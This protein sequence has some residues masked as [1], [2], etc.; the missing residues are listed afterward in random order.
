MVNTGLVMAF[1]SIASYITS[2]YAEWFPIVFLAAIAFTMIIAFIYVL[3]KLA[4][5]NGIA[6]W[7]RIKIYEIFLSVV[8]IFA[9]L[10]VTSIIFSIDFSQL[11]G[12]AGI[13]PA[14][15]PADCPPSLFPPSDLITLSVCNIHRFNQNVLNLNQF[16]YGIGLRFSF[17]PSLTFN[18][19]SLI[20][21]TTEIE[22]LGGAATISPP[23]AFSVFTGWVIDALYGAY[24]LAQMQYI[25]LSASLLLFTILMALGLVSRMFVATRSFGAAMI[26]LGLG[27]GLMYPLMVSI[28]YGWLNVQLD[29]YWLVFG[30]GSALTIVFGIVGLIAAAIFNIL[31]NGFWTPFIGFLEF[32]G[33][34]ALGLT[35]IPILNLV[36]VD[37]FVSDFSRAFGEK[38]DFLSLLFKIV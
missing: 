29:K 22:G 9:F 21:K 28:T 11:L 7:A 10:F 15:S 31:L 33:F 5:R 35:V 18:A 23:S 36:V 3:S 1:T 24:V 12:G 38:I 14:F 32:A 26:A 20:L 6:I 19:S 25:I 16:V 30:F 8:L 4:G 13:V 17:F 37:V 2:P 34:A 27:I